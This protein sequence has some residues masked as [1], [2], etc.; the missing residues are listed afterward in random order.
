MGTM[1]N[2]TLNATAAVV[3]ATAEAA[4]ADPTSMFFVYACL[5]TS[6]P[7]LVYYGSQRS[8]DQPAEETMT[9]KDAMMF[10]VVGSC[11]LFGLFLVF[12]FFA[13]EYINMLL[14]VYF[15]FLGAVCIATTVH[16]WLVRIMG[17]DTTKKLFSF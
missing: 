14:H 2:A 8:T 4:A 17:E 10:P 11:V 5:L 13:K 9:T 15:I 16:P 7:A 6:A 1:E 3:N 12:K